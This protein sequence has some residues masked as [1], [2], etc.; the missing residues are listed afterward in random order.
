LQP[1]GTLSAGIS[2]ISNP[3][4]GVLLTVLSI[5]LAWT[6][7]V[8]TTRPGCRNEMSLEH[9]IDDFKIRKI[10]KYECSFSWGFWWFLFERCKL[11]NIPASC[12]VSIRYVPQGGEEEQLSEKYY[13]DTPIKNKIYRP[14]KLKSKRF[15]RENFFR[16]NAI[17]KVTVIIETPF[18]RDTYASKVKSSLDNSVL[19]LWSENSEEIRNFEYLLDKSF[20]LKG[21][22]IVQG[23]IKSVNMSIPY[24]PSPSF[25]AKVIGNVE[26]DVTMSLIV[27][28]PPRKSDRTDVIKVKLS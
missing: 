8:E 26:E 2:F 19:S 21:M 11:R 3:I 18:E 17:E 24:P 6:I 16:R 23:V 14:L 15:S 12:T 22:S 1:I 20:K 7:W 5:L 28:L 10:E 9:Y 25:I 27:D 4:F 13:D